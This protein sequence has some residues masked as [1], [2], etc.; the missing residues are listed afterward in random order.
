MTLT[1]LSHPHFERLTRLADSIGRSAVA[2]GRELT[3]SVAPSQRS[4]QTLFAADPVELRPF[5][6]ACPFDEYIGFQSLGERGSHTHR[7][8]ASIEGAFRQLHSERISGCDAFRDRD[9]LGQFS[10][11]G[12]T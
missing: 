9:R 12:V 5:R 7:V 2:T 3:R 11:A 6:A 8:I 1:F 10:P 4:L